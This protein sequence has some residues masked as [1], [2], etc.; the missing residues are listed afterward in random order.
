VVALDDNFSG[1]QHFGWG[2]AMRLDRLSG[3]QMGDGSGSAP[4]H[5]RGR[6]SRQMEARSM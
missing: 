2:F 5:N 1:G 6:A 3:L 4:T